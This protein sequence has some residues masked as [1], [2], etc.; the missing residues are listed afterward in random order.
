MVSRLWVTRRRWLALASMALA[1]PF[2]AAAAHAQGYPVRAIKLICPYPPGG[3]TDIIARS[4]AQ[5]LSEQLSRPVVVENK[6]GAG[7]TIGAA[8]GARAA[9]D[10]YTIFIGEPGGLS[11]AAA[12]VKGLAY[13]PMR[14]F[15]PIA[16]VVSVPMA[17][18]AHP[19]INAKNLAE[20][21]AHA[22]A[23][24]LTLNYGS[25][26]TGTVQH[27]T[28]ERL[29]IASGLP[30]AH[31]PYKGG[32]PAM[33]DLLGGQIP[34]LMVTLPTVAAHLKSGKLVA[35]GVLTRERHPLYPHVPTIGEAGYAGFD[36]GIWQGILAPAGTPRDIVERL[37][38]ELKQAMAA[39]E[40]RERLE[41]VGADVIVTTPEA[42]GALIRDDVARWK[43]VVQD[44]GIAL[45][46]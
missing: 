5:R 16:Q 46:N 29:R 26:G 3:A 11:I 37:H 41:G 36:I 28:M 34:L 31:I 18:V 4:I 43:K 33:N 6:A 21:A 35:M 30:F 2:A 24:K 8:E 14:D 17:L 39:K 15:A 22:K 20:L 12:T 23:T 25:P 32:A 38:G 44:A 19:S 42:F 7:G 40:V 45:G 27:L 1:L 13:D 9:P 10:G